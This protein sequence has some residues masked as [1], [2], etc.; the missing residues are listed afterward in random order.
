MMGPIRA[1]KAGKEKKK[2]R[3]VKTAKAADPVR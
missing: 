3:P 2:D 1:G